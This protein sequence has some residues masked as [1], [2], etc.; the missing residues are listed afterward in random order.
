MPLSEV[1]LVNIKLIKLSELQLITES[2]AEGRKK[3]SQLF[4]ND[5]DRL[6]SSLTRQSVI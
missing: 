1:R 3:L 2:G 6:I 5:Q 4:S